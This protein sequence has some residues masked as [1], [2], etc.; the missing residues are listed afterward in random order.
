MFVGVHI[1]SACYSN[2]VF[3]VLQNFKMSLAFIWTAV[4]SVSHI[5]NAIDLYLPA[6]AASFLCLCRHNKASQ[7]LD[8]LMPIIQQQYEPTC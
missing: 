3:N 8:L 2:F 5:C 7:R 6:L 1:D 4:G